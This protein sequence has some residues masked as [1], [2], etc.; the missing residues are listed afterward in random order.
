MKLE[1]FLKTR[2]A[3]D[4]MFNFDATNVHCLL[5][6]RKYSDAKRQQLIK[7]LSE[8]KAT[9]ETQRNQDELNLVISA[10]GIT[11]S[12][13]HPACAEMLAPLQ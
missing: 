1:P 7:D 6:K 8:V 9:P 13:F 5:E 2:D 4:V 10:V 11:P 3:M 12:N